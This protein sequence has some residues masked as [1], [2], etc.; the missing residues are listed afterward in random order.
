MGLKGFTT[1]GAFLSFALVSDARG[2]HALVYQPSA[3]YYVWRRKAAQ[4]Y[5]CRKRGTHM[6]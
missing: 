3:I 6:V 2:R 5:G 4:P 1:K